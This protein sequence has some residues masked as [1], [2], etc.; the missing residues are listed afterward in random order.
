MTPDD[1]DGFVYCERGHRHWGLYGA[2]GLLLTDPERGVLLQH[3]AWWT[4]HGETW[5]LPGGA[6]RGHESARE[7]ATREAEEEA[8]VPV[9][10]VR[11]TA[12]SVVDHGGWTYTT[13]LAG[14][15]H[16]V[17]ERV[18]NEESAELR[19]VPP[20]EVA[21]FPLHR[22]FAAAWPSLHEQLGRELVLVVDAANVVGSRPDGW[23]RDRAGAAE[24]LRDRLSGLVH[25]GVRGADIGLGDH[26][27]SWWPRVRMVVEGQARDVAPADDV[28]VIAA[29]RDGDSQIV[30][31]V[32]KARDARPEDHV[33]V[34]TA[35]REL[36]SRVEA[37]GAGVLGPS[38]FLNLVSE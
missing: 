7:A 18:V 37:E 16:P 12:E 5:A 33:V 32:R 21:S 10:A 26:A 27:W 6:R 24:R 1:G 25:T 9:A 8:A 34:V 23:W 35:D 2:A 17:R 31:S 29:V 20:E 3:R 22:D 11:P 14:T 28:E 15:R 13:V 4:H 36:R 19:W 38:A 30:E